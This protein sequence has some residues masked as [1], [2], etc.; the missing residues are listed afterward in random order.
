MESK[1]TSRQLLAMAASGVAPPR[2]PFAPTVYEHGAGLIGRSMSDTARD[3]AL[4]AQAQMA[5]YELYRPDIVSVGLDVYNVE[6]EALGCPM[7]YPEQGLPYIAG[8]IVRSPGDVARLSLPDPRSAERMPVMLAAARAVQRSI[9]DDV[10]VNAAMVG[11]FTLAAILRGFEDFVCDLV[12]E[13]EFAAS[14]LN[15]A[16]ACLLDYGRS[17]A[18][19]GVG[20]AVNE[21]WVAPPL[22]SPGMFRQHALPY[23]QRLIAGLKQAG[24]ASVS[25]IC[26]G[27]T[28]QIARDLARTGSSLLMADYAADRLQY[29]RL[30]D[31]AGIVLRASVQ[32]SAVEAGGA[33]LAEQ[34]RRVIFEAAPGGRF[35]FGCGVVSA[36]TPP[37]NVLELKGVAGDL[38]EEFIFK[39][40]AR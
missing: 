33:A 10:P 4:L 17:L 22:L 5:A 35:V 20:V 28:T 21:S 8:P 39:E 15:F 24:A 11:P 34:A 2:L 9:G 26:G 29:K 16:A 25:L 27:D 14:L 23:E 3:P 31:E 37:A 18:R 40:G 13:P 32:S 6:A 38:Y 12:A 1:L 30:C 7:V 36:A 19:C